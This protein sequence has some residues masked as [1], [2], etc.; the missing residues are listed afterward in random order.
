MSLSLFQSRRVFPRNVTLGLKSDA[1][2]LSPFNFL[3]LLLFL[4][5]VSHVCVIFSPFPIL[6]LLSL[7]LSYSKIDESSPL[8]SIHQS[9]FELNEHQRAEEK[10]DSIYFIPNPL[11]SLFP[12]R[13]FLILHFSILFFSFFFAF[14]F[15]FLSSLFSRPFL[16]LFFPLF[17]LSSDTI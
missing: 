9:V 5:L 17:S 2:S 12:F 11:S 16:A 1:G 4:S 14:H 15:C 8:P 10:R 3:P 6:L 7:F 13:S